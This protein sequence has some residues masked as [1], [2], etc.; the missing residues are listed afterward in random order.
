MSDVSRVTQRVK[1]PS[2]LE[3]LES[4]L[5]EHQPFGVF[6]LCFC[7]AYATHAYILLLM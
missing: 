2:S 6:D 5:A 4:L 1:G 3:M 7:S